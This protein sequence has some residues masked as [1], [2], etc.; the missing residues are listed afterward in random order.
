M[1]KLILISTLVVALV[2]PATALAAFMSGTYAGKTSQ[3]GPV[4]FK[5]TQSKVSK[6]RIGVV[7]K[8]TDGDRFQTVLPTKTSYFP[9]QNITSGNY[10]AS[11]TGS[12]GASKYVNKG[13]IVNRR[14]NGTFIGTRKYNTNDDLDPNGTVICRTGN[15]TY[16]VPRTG[17]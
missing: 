5:A 7:W 2:V 15:V 12:G 14:A 3:G 13:K 11:F 6:F 4:S 16:S 10:N 8:C 9:S 1:K 17:P